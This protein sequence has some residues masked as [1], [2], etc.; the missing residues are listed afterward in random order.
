M[1][2][3]TPIADTPAEAHASM[4]EFV[5]RSGLA[6]RDDAT[7]TAIFG[8]GGSG[9]ANDKSRFSPSQ[10]LPSALS[11]GD[12]ANKFELKAAT[13]KTTTRRVFGELDPINPRASFALNMQ[14]AASSANDVDARS[15]A[16][17]RTHEGAVKRPP[18]EKENRAP[19][20]SAAADAA[21]DEA[22]DENTLPKPTPQVDESASESSRS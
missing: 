8:G 1:P 3:C 2:I 18:L 12:E 14:T 19:P 20:P 13:A 15:S 7:W 21:F 9:E 4:A 17:K 16:K 5:T 22:D 11:A 6:Q 10:P